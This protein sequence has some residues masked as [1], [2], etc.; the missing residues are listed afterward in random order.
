VKILSALSFFCG[1]SGLRPAAAGLRGVKVVGATATK[2]TPT[3][4]NNNKNSII[5]WIGNLASGESVDIT[6]QVCGSLKGSACGTT[7]FLSG[8]WSAAYT[9]PDTLLPAKTDYTDRFSIEVICP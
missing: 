3:I 9:D 5:T 8:P 4:K 6:V 2:G 7:Q 1:K